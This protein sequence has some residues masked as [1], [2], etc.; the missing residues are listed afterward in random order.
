MLDAVLLEGIHCLSREVELKKLLHKLVELL[1][2]NV[3]WQKYLIIVNQFPN[4]KPWSATEQ[5]SAQEEKFL[6]IYLATA[7]AGELSKQIYGEDIAISNYQAEIPW[8]L[9]TY[10]EFYG[11]PIFVEQATEVAELRQD[12]YLSQQQPENFLGVPLLDQDN[13][14]GIVYLENYTNS[15]RYTPE[16]QNFIQVLVTQTTIL[17]RHLELEKKQITVVLEKQIKRALL[18]EKITQE[19]RSNLDIT[20]IF[21]VTVEQI[22]Q[23]FG[24]NRCLIHSYRADSVLL[25]KAEYLNNEALSLMGYSVPIKDNLHARQ[26]LSQDK[27]IATTDVYQ[28]PLFSQIHDIC[29]KTKIKSILAIRTSYHGQPNGVI[30]LHQC[31]RSRQWTNDEIEILESLAIQV[32]IA[33]AHAELLEK[34]STQKQELDH[35]NQLLQLEIAEKERAQKFLK[36]IIDNIPQSI[37]WKDKNSIYLGSNQNFLNDKK[38][39]SEA[40]IIGKD[41]YDLFDDHAEAD[42]YREC[43]ARIMKYDMAEYHI[44]ETQ[45]RNDGQRIWLDTSKIPLHNKEGEVIG[46]LGIYEDVTD[47]KE[48]EYMLAKQLQKERFLGIITSKIRQSLNSQQILQTAVAQI[49]Q[50]FGVNRCIL[51]DIESP[52]SFLTVMAQYIRANDSIDSPILLPDNPYLEKILSQ[53]AAI[54]TN[55]VYQDALFTTIQ[56]LCQQINLK[57]ILAIQTSYQDKVNGVIVL[58]QCDR[59]REWSEDEIELLEAAAIQVGIAIAQ[60]QLLEQESRQKKILQQQSAAIEAATEGIAILV[61]E[62]YIYVNQSHIKIFGYENKEEL[63]GQNWR[64]LYSQDEISRLEQEMLPV[65]QEQGFWQGEAIASR[66]DGTIFDEEISLTLNGSQLVCICRDISDNKQAEKEIIASQKR[67]KTLTTAAPVGIFQTDVSG[68]CTYVNER[69]SQIAGL[70]LEEAQGVGWLKGIHLNDRARINQEWYEAASQN[71]SFKS[72]YRFL[73]SHGE[74][75]WVFGQAV[76][77][78]DAEGNLLGYLG[79]ITDIN[80]LKKAEKILA[81]KLRR[82]QLLGHIT[83]QIR[84]SLDTQQIFRTAVTQIGQVFQVSRCLIHDYIATP[85]PV[86]P[87]VA[88]YLAQEEISV[89]EYK[90][91]LDNYSYLQKVLMQEFAVASCNIN[92]DSLFNPFLDKYQGLNLKSI[93]AVRTSYQDKT[94][95]VIALHQCDRFRKWTTEEINLLEAV[96]EQVGIALAQ[97]RL[98]AKEKQQ[99]AALNWKNLALEKAKQEAEVANQ[100]KSQFIA[101]MSHELRTPLNV[102]LGFCQLLT[103]ESN[104]SPTHE[105]YIETIKRNGDNLLDLINNILDI[106]KIE[107]GNTN[108]IC[109]DFNFYEFILDLK[110][111]FYLQAKSKGLHLQFQIN[112]EVPRY[113][114]G[115]PGKIRQIL[116]NL[117]SNAIKFTMQGNVSLTISWHDWQHLIFKVQDTG[118]G[119]AADELEDL[120]KPFVQTKTGIESCQGTGLGLSISQSLVQLLGGKIEVETVVGRGTTFMVYLPF[121]QTS[122]SE[123]DKPF[124]SHLPDISMKEISGYNYEEELADLSAMSTEWLEQLNYAANAANERQIYALI[125]E[126][127]PSHAALA[128]RLKEMVYNFALE[129]IIENTQKLLQRPD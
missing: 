3:P 66:K 43:D 110:Q 47:W 73:N 53:E 129:G 91:D 101:K 71:I 74:T 64:I 55:N 79:S 92:K 120:F 28:D 83:R 38:L 12:L 86:L 6:A 70:T 5:V 102:I 62:Q 33:I 113:V 78:Y 18:L 30:A 41:D 122:K 99:I 104:L 126:I 72:E 77:E 65:L 87:V 108:V 56:D 75:N 98:L 4:K 61:D 121:R 22:G 84:Q 42:W 2:Q 23:V 26:V 7:D 109:E 58:H 39:T 95:G 8:A 59:F 119:I 48:A 50:F 51:H 115:D 82:E 88:E 49:G 63:I 21:K 25:V 127:I 35:K 27:A 103:L 32:G 67:Y 15:L 45:L 10:L 85:E 100:T 44:I 19:I 46:I 37:F 36:L 40:E 80:S 112:P 118:A 60:A 111:T 128:N 116:I 29:R 105:E 34:K 54:A 68:N 106:S 97:A 20:H 90:I 69:W 89:L 14:Y 16:I 117:L 96:A 76:A 114:T 13:F 125:A 57:S 1:H 24:V 94:N 124:Q 123:L 107:S 81:S 11:Q 31:D 9:V 52:G 17:L 93:L